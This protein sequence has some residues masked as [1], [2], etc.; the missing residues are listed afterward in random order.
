[1]NVTLSR[2]KAG[3]GFGSAYSECSEH[4]RQE[5]SEKS[6]IA[7]VDV[8]GAWSPA[9]LRAW[10]TGIIAAG[11]DARSLL[12]ASLQGNVIPDVTEPAR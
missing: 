3:L 9:S 11:V 5:A 6:F 10:T 8:G 12:D 1:L 7:A 4:G 2:E